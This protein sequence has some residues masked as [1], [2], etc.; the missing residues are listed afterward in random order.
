MSNIDKLRKHGVMDEVVLETQCDDFFDFADTENYNRYYMFLT[1]KEF[2]VLKVRGVFNR[3]QVLKKYDLSDIR[4]SANLPEFF[5]I[6]KNVRE[7]G[8][9]FESGYI[10]FTVQFASVMKGVYFHYNNSEEKKE[11]QKTIS[12]WCKKIKNIYESDYV[13][14]TTSTNGILTRY[15]INCGAQMQGR[16]GNSVS[17]SGCGTINKF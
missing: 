3:I 17:C 4:T 1:R 15:C 13:L 12:L 14:W 10:G 7:E 2:I 8:T 11:K 5:T 16:K 6:K 9:E